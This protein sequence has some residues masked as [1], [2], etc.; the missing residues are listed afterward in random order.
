MHAPVALQVDC[1]VKTLFSQC[2]AAQT[3]PVRYLRQLP[4]PSHLPSVPHEAAVWSVQIWW[5]SLPP[6]AT[7]VQRPIDDGSA[8]LL[9]APWQAFSQQTPSTQKLLAHS[10]AA[11][12]AWPFAFGPQLPFTHVCPVTQS[13]SPVQRPMQALP[14]QW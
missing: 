4:A 3:V 13:A 2:W 11:V 6:A 14:L 8:Q 12:H 9:H 5:G 1:G 7:G 10:L